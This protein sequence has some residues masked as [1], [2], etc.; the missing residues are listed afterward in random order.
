MSEIQFH[1][2]DIIVYIISDTIENKRLG[3]IIKDIV[4]DRDG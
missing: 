2:F 4:F 1:K 3:F